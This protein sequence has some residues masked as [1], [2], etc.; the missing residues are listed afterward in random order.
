LTLSSNPGTDNQTICHNIPVANI[1]YTVGGS[2]T[3]ASVSGLPN[4]V[5]GLFNEG[6]FTISGTP[7]E[8]GVFN[9][10]VITTGTISPCLEDTA[11]GTI[12]VNPAPGSTGGESA[13]FDADSSWEVPDGVS[14]ITVEAWGGGGAGGGAELTFVGIGG[15]G[16]GGAYAIKN[17]LSVAPYQTMGIVVAG[18]VEGVPAGNGNDGGHST[19]SGFED[20]I[21]AAGGKGGTESVFLSPYPYGGSGGK[22][23]DSKG[24]CAVNGTDGLNGFRVTFVLPIPVPTPVDGAGGA[25]A[26]PNGGAGG[27]PVGELVG[28]GNPGSAP[29]GGG[30]G[31]RSAVSLSLN[32][33]GGAGASG[34]VVVYYVCPELTSAGEIEGTQTICYNTAPDTITNKTSAAV[35]TGSVQYKWQSSTTGSSVGFADINSATGSS[36]VPDAMTQTTWFKRFSKSK[37][38]STW[39]VEGESNVIQITVRTQ[40]SSGEIDTT[41]QEFCSNGNPAEIPSVS[42]ASGGDENIGYQWQSSANGTFNDANIISGATLSTFT[43]PAL[44]AT[45]TYRRTASDGTCNTYTASSGTWKVTVYPNSEGGNASGGTGV[46]YG[47]NSTVLTLSGHTGLVQSWQYSTNGTTWTDIPGTTDNTYTADSLIADTWFRAMVKS[48]ICQADSS[49]ATQITMITNYHI[50]GYAKYDNIPKTPLS[51]LKVILV[52]NSTILVDSVVTNNDGFYQFN[53]LINGNYKLQ[54]ISAHP[55]RQWQT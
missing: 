37:C 53:N 5:S 30:S 3:G 52:K 36:Y 55:S 17:S 42:A 32:T 12:T 20:Q 19:I 1:T 43:P 48:G 22:A 28:D 4:G 9:Y 25:G 2:A 29:G 33:T 15:G 47:S 10:S 6:V 46:C 27:N 49:S 35:Q 54:V 39:P 31:S 45:T 21:Y 41:G 44:S 13:V 34:R 26:T 24:D 8:S 7:T 51:G 11:I 38:S 18:T 16:G 50:S 14:N 23:S 40:F